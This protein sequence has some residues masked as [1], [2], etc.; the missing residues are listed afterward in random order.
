MKKIIKPLILIAICLLLFVSTIYVVN[1]KYLLKISG[2]SKI[3]IAEPITD[4]SS[5]YTPSGEI[6]NEPT[7]VAYIFKVSNYSGTKIN[8]VKQNYTLQFITKNNNSNIKNINFTVYKTQ[9]IDI[10]NKIKSATDKKATIT[11]NNLQAI[12]LDTNNKFTAK[13]TLNASTKQDDYY[14]FLINSITADKDIQDTLTVEINSESA[15]I[16]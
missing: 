9:S 15:K 1:S 2:N 6:T 14:I 3:E 5:F 12:T 10:A 7:N 4:L 11:A 13:Q 8:E 16:E